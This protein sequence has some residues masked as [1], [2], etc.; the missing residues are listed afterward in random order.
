MK[1]SEEVENTFFVKNSDQDMRLLLI[2]PRWHNLYGTFRFIVKLLHFEPPLGLCYLAS[3]CE[4]EGI[5]TD[6]ID[7]EAENFEVE[8]L[9]TYIK[10]N[11]P[12]FVG[13]TT[14]TPT[15][16]EVK[17]IASEIKRNF[18][19]P[20][21][22]G[23]PHVTL[24]GKGVL[25]EN[26][27]FDF[28]LTNDCE[29]RLPMFLKALWEGKNI[30]KVKGLIYRKN[31]EIVSTEQPADDFPLDSLPFPAREKLKT[32]K[33]RWFVPGVGE[34]I[35]TTFQTSRGCSMRC[36]FC[37]ERV[38]YPKV[39]FRTPE[40][41]IEEMKSIKKNHPEIK[42]II[43]VDDTI[44]LV[45]KRAFEIFKLMEEEKL[46]FTFECET[47]ANR[48][49]EKLA[50]QMVRAGLKRIN[51]GIESA[52]E[53]I[54]NLIGKGTN[55]KDIK[56]AYKI[57]KS[58][59]VETRGSVIIGLPYENIK[60]IAETIRFISSLKELDFAYIN[61]ATPYPGTILR[62]LVMEGKGGTKLYY[63]GYDMRRYGSA[64]IGVGMLKPKHLVML[65][66]IAVLMFYLRPRRILYVIR[67]RGVGF[68]MRILVGF[69]LGNLLDIIN[70]LS[71]KKR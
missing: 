56:R 16:Y 34:S 23:G 47:V 18:K 33:Y 61:I 67:S 5:K 12:D 7:C 28:A 14:T 54:L 26:S 64:V 32:H 13:I 40:N 60:T 71:K 6:I 46:G 51:F 43:F 52:D 11:T 62:D 45:P 3:S 39:K 27:E 65:Q 42:H 53:R 20:I 59:G 29:I 36:I 21:I 10:N 66:K 58:L 31:G 41:V 69:V 50:E 37:S 63:H 30:E 19:L 1:D 70:S 24:V 25:E 49:D 68:A 2:S 57:V 8:D 44:T 48:I 35:A 15:I 4:R 9:L 22:V 38:L 55:L 17:R